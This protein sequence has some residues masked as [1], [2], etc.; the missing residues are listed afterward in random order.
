[1]FMLLAFLCRAYRERFRKYSTPRMLAAITD[2]IRK[3][4]S[5]GTVPI[6]SWSANHEFSRGDRTGIV[7]GG[8]NRN[9]RLLLR[10]LWR[11][12]GMARSL[13]AGRVG[14]R[15]RRRAGLVS[16]LFQRDRRRH[17]Y[18]MCILAIWFGHLNGTMAIGG[19]L[20]IG[21]FCISFLWPWLFFAV[22]GGIIAFVS[23]RKMDCPSRRTTPVAA[24]VLLAAA[25]LVACGFAQLRFSR[26]QPV[27]MF[28]AVRFFLQ[29]IAFSPDGKSLVTVGGISGLDKDVRI[30]DATTGRALGECEKER[31]NNGTENA[32]VQCYG[33]PPVLAASS[34]LS[35][36][37]RSDNK[38]IIQIWD[39][40]TQ[41]PKQRF[42]WDDSL[43][44]RQSVFSRRRPMVCL[45]QWASPGVRFAVRTSSR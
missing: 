15:V 22:V 38:I 25:G 5:N 21:W 6:I 1:M 3:E 12:L 28:R 29:G 44:I 13:D 19:A 17:N 26:E 7:L 31:A 14:R 10:I 32:A 41:E 16:W 27:V 2:G 4:Q 8:G 33:N 24:G 9:R 42:Q 35:A 34:Y 37:P 18:Q 36:F 45:F 43:E 30:W 23:S 11:R 39:L 20:D 40:A